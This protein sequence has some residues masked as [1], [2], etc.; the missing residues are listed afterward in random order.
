MNKTKN[1]L[2]VFV[3]TSVFGGCFDDEFN[4]KSKKFF[5]QVK[6]G[7]FKVVISETIIKELEKSPKEVKEL[8][9]TIPQSSLEI[10]DIDVKIEELRDAYIANKIVGEKSLGDAEHIAVA[11]ISAVDLIVSWNFKHYVR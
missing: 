4:E 10:I 3:D 2:R 5:D 1:K 8:F 11:T 7:S 6:N 9:A